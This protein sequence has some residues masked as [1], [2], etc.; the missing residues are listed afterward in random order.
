MTKP[1][2]PDPASCAEIPGTP[3]RA[4]RMTTMALGDLPGRASCP[5][6]R[7]QIAHVRR[8]ARGAVRIPWPPGSLVGPLD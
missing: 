4:A 7:A 3:E 8:R 5:R 2:R 1:V 6:S